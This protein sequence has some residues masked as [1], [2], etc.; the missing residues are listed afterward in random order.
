MV[1]KFDS[2]QHLM[3]IDAVFTV[4]KLDSEETYVAISDSNEA[5]N[6]SNAYL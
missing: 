2:N 3:I 1:A 4:A 6:D 5:K